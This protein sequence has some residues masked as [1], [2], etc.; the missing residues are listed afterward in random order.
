MSIFIKNKTE[1]FIEILQL[2]Y[3]AWINTLSFF[4][5]KDKIN[6]CLISFFQF[7]MHIMKIYVFYFN[8]MFSL[9]KGSIIYLRRR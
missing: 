8:L 4:T 3:R 2:Y 6:S 7:H 1:G 9:K 5:P